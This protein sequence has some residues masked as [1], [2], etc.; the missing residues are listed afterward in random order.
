MTALELLIS[1]DNDAMS[2]LGVTETVATVTLAQAAMSDDRPCWNNV[3]NKF[4]NRPS[5]DNWTKR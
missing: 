1:A 5:W 2:R 4:D 3:E